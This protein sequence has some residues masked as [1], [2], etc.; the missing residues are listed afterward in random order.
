MRSHKYQ[1][2]YTMK[3]VKPRAIISL[4]A[5]IILMT[6]CA[7]QSEI[8]VSTDHSMANFDQ[9]DS[10]QWLPESK[11]DKPENDLI[12][13]RIISGIEET[14]TAKGYHQSEMTPDIYVD[15]SVRRADKIS[16]DSHQ[17]YEGYA[18]GFTWRRGY[19]A[20]ATESKVGIIETNIIEYIEGS[21]V[22]DIIDSNN[23]QIIWRGIGTK[24]LPENFDFKVTD[25]AI[26]NIVT[27][28]LENYP[29]PIE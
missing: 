19:G 21:L 28:I 26:K 4:M 18:P 11:G 3:T 12:S 22:I 7:S 27:V 24:Q 8:D 17:T 14:L 10:Y 29:P 25:R 2:E 20:Q 5:S 23:M 1:K 13:R 16:I 15:Y 6:G 9:F